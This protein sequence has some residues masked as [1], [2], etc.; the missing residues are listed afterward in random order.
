[1]TF[2][3]ATRAILIT[4]VEW[5][6]PLF[7]TDLLFKAVAFLLLAPLATG[8][9]HL[10]LWASGTGTLAD[11]DI[12]FF[13]AKPVGWVVLVAFGAV[14]LGITAL[15]QAALLALLMAPQEANIGMG[16]AVFWSIRRGRQV[17]TLAGWLV[18]IT[19]VVVAPFLLVAAGIA[20]ATLGDF[21]IN[22]YL[23]ERPPAFQIAVA[24]GAGL[25]MLLGLVLA[26]LASGWI[27]ALPMVLFER[28]AP[29]EALARSRSRVAGSRRLVVALILA[30]GLASV[31]I[32]SLTTS[33]IVL[34]ARQLVPLAVG[35]LARLVAAIG[36]T[37]LVWFAAG[38][39]MNLLATT[40]FAVLLV[41]T[42]RR[43]SPSHTTQLTACAGVSSSENV[44]QIRLG[45]RL[46]ALVSVGC[47]LMATVGAVAAQRVRFDD[48]VTV[49][50]HRGAGGL[51]PE[52]TLAAIDRAIEVRADWVEVDVQ[53]TSDGEVVVVHDSD[54]MKLAG[55][56]LKVWNA[57]WADVESIDVG[58][59]FDPA[60]TGEQVPT[61][62]QVLERCRG[63]VGVNIELK[64]YGHG[65][66]LEE[67]VAGIVEACGMEREVIL[68]SLKPAVVSRMKALRPNWTVGLLMSLAVGDVK[69]LQADFLA[70][71]AQFVSRGFVDRAHRA[72][73]QVYAWTTNDPVS[74]SQMVSR[75][76]DGVI[77]DYPDLARS[78]LKQRN[79]LSPVERILLEL[80]AVLGVKTSV[81]PQ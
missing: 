58:R 66:R 59:R 26:W 14:S 78:V 41:E 15:E 12:V 64:D 10:C 54:F 3:Q 71:N 63:K 70:V 67:R 72:G 24:C 28:V 32:S 2:P 48:D 37:L 8:L 4:M 68:M 44:S 16:A 35:G 9:L 74:I 76:V 81:E 57:T 46:V 19:A 22:Y 79:E 77:T 18:A 80:A 27:L 55:V 39:M 65:Q 7:L 38:L 50:G 73:K 61:L 23:A 69:Q 31:V 11:A 47:F 51:A 20:W 6:R 34:V 13:F 75:G 42:Y 29:R 43:L 49:M 60:F 40:S 17:I 21:D 30:W 5:W 45:R 53:E 36:A 52:N 1:M 33:L 25:A 56:N 62:T